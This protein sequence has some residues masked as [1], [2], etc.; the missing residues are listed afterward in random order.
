MFKY[1]GIKKVTG[2]KIFG[3][4]KKHPKAFLLFF[5][6]YFTLEMLPWVQMEPCGREDTTGKG[7]AWSWHA[8]A[9]CRQEIAECPRGSGALGT[10]AFLQ[11]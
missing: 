10:S 9:S 11:G 2:K 7:K 4:K 8:A 1:F 3:K 5:L 6:I